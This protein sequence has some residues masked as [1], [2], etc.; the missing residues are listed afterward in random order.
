MERQKVVSAHLSSEQI[1]P[2]VFAE[3]ECRGEHSAQ[4][5][6]VKSARLFVKQKVVF[7]LH[8]DAAVIHVQMLSCSATG[9][10]PLIMAL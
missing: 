5:K 3:R 4:I 10:V 7:L 9:Y 6:Y 2:F 1:L 8:V